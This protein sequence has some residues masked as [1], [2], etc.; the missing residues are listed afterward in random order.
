MTAG[1]FTVIVLVELPA[2]SFFLFGP[3]GTG[4]TTWLRSVLPDAHWVDLLVD[5]ELLRLL[6]DPGRF[7]RQPAF[8]PGDQPPL[9]PAHGG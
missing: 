9:L 6:R 5:R 7:S 2:R 4:K 8:G 1:I 3:R